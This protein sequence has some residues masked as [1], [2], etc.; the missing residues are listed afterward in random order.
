MMTGEELQ[1][2]SPSIRKNDSHE[3]GHLR[4]KMAYA[5]AM[6]CVASFPLAR[7]LPRLFQSY[8]FLPL[9]CVTQ[10]Y[11]SAINIVLERARF[12]C[13]HLFAIQTRLSLLQIYSTIRFLKHDQGYQ[14]DVLEISSP[15]IPVDATHSDKCEFSDRDVD[16]GDIM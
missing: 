16:L 3:A 4:C 15:E 2:G 8:S 12:T 14:S 6:P 5:H 1:V 10:A 9:P 13:L 11:D 7:A